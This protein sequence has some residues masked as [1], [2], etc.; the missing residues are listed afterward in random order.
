MCDAGFVQGVLRATDAYD[1]ECANL[2]LGSY[3]QRFFSWLGT[4]EVMAETLAR[5]ALEA[6]CQAWPRP[7]ADRREFKTIQISNPCCSVQIS[8]GEGLEE[9][10]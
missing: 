2:I 3:A 1:L 7:V 8:T 9:K 5:L 10:N 6:A 4:S